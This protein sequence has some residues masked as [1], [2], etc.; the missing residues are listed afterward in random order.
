M[1]KEDYYSKVENK[2]KKDIKPDDQVKPSVPK[3]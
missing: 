3:P 2:D 1:T